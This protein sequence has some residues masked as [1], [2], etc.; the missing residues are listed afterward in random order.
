MP[1]LAELLRS[2]S[3]TQRLRA[4]WCACHLLAAGA[5]AALAHG[6]LALAALSRLML[7][8]ALGATLCVAV[9]VLGN[10]EV[11]GRS[12]IRHPF[13]LARAEVLAGFA[14]SV[15]LLF[16]GFDIVSHGAEHLLEGLWAAHVHDKHVRGGGADAAALLALGATTVSAVVLRNHARISKGM[17]WKSRRER[18]GMA[19]D[20]CMCVCGTAMRFAALDQLPGVLANPSHLLTIACSALLLL[21]P[22]LDAPLGA[23]LDRAV[24]V[25]VAGAM[26][27]IGLRLVRALGSMLL[28]SY[29]GVGVDL[30]VAEIRDD[31]GVQ[32]LCESRF[33][34]AHHGLCIAT[35]KVRA[36]KGTDEGRLRERLGRLVRE[37][38]RGERWEVS[39]AITTEF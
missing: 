27:A 2:L 25:A 28:L 7:F 11:W 21:M 24:A 10:F 33:W 1:T 6:S 39:V 19:A 37:R 3:R 9:D 4:A 31:P 26:I 14:T 30:V 23:M 29:A 17:W 22:L 15:L 20:V 16:M 38:L 35:V 36:A 12:S 8:D 32:E 18:G 5:A 34:Q 13:G